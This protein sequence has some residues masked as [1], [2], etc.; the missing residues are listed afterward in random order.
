MLLIIF[1]QLWQVKVQHEAKE[2]LEENFLQTISVTEKDLVWLNAGEVVIGGEMFDIKSVRHQNGRVLLTGLFDKKETAIR[3]I[4]AAESGHSGM[5]ISILQLL[6]ILQSI[7][8]VCAILSGLR[9]AIQLKKIFFFLNASCHFNYSR[10]I[11]P[12]PKF[13]FCI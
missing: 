8:L 13:W 9:P 6:L 12:P 2:K 5:D 3:N 4:L 10:V 11:I 7:A 1:L